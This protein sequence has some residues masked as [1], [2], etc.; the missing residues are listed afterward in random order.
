MLWHVRRWLLLLAMGM[1]RLS[2]QSRLRASRLLLQLRIHM[3]SEM[4]V[5]FL[6]SLRHVFGLLGAP[7]GAIV[8]LPNLPL[9]PFLFLFV[10]ASPRVCLFRCH[11]PLSGTD[12]SVF[13]ASRGFFLPLE[14][15]PT[16]KNC[17]FGF[18]FPSEEWR[19]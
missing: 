16:R 12:P 3:A 8:R 10:I 1:R 11:L 6:C 19:Q 7:L 4:L 15:F 13:F 5:V 14:G 2:L 17:E 9:L 18:A